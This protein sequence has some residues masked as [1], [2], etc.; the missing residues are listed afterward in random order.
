[1][2]N[3]V[4]RTAAPRIISSAYAL[5]L[6]NRTVEF[7]PGIGCTKSQFGALGFFTGAG[8]VVENPT[9]IFRSRRLQ[10][11]RALREKLG[12]FFCVTAITLPD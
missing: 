5:N 4:M 7:Q 9:L 2:I 10:P 3:I 1:L 6:P 8:H 12:K 11:A